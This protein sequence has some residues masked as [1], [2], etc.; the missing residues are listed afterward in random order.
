MLRILLPTF[1]MNQQLRKVFF[2]LGLFLLPSV[3]NANYI[4]GVGFE[5]G[6]TLVRIDSQTGQYTRLSRLGTFYNSLAQNSAG[7]LFGGWFG[8]SGDNGRVSRFDSSTGSI[9][10]TFN[11]ATPGAGSSRGL[12]FDSN[13]NL[14]AVINRNDSSGSPTLNDDLYSFDLVNESTTRIGSLGFKGVQGFDISPNNT[15]Y[16]WDVVEGLLIVDPVTGNA[17]DL[18]L[19]IGGTGDIQSIAFAPDGSLFGAREN[20]YRIDPTTGAFDQ[21]GV[22]LGFDIRGIEFVVPEP[23]GGAMMLSILTIVF[24]VPVRNLR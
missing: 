8:S 6:T 1:S 4:V 13:D 20:L 10:E 23:T 5:S 7:E 17:T 18:N 19:T 3:A 16:A 24:L 21:I 11:T 15:F 22:G 9:L 12:S 14:F 2:G